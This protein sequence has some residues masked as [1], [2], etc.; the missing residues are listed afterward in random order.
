MQLVFLGPLIPGQPKPDGTPARGRRETKW[1]SWD[2]T[3]G[4]ELLSL[5]GHAAGVTAVAFSGDGAYLASACWDQKVRVWS[6]P[7]QE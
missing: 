1:L 7:R 6:A 4:R 3:S 5:V 2:L